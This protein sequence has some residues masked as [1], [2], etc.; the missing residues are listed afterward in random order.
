MLDGPQ[1]VLV[2]LP[3]HAADEWLA[4]LSQSGTSKSVKYFKIR[5]DYPAVFTTAV[6][7]T[8]TGFAGNG[9]AA[10]DDAL[11]RG[12]GWEGSAR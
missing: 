3:Y 12:G 7:W 9:E 2:P 11:M 6:S 4:D 5:D 8:A 10:A 1:I